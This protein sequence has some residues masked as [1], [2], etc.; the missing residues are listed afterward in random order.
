MLHPATQPT[1][2]LRL[3]IVEDEALVAME[4][5]MILADAG[6]RPV[7]IADD[8]ASARR[9]A[10]G[11][12]ADLALVDMQLAGGSSGLDV[13][14]VLADRGIPVLFVTGNCPDAAG[15]GLAIGCLHKPVSDGGLAIAVE[16]AARLI[17]G[18]PPRRLPGGMHLYEAARTPGG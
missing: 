18:Q 8:L 7:G 13:A 15:A 4:M 6:H 14:R 5:E 17:A 2:S 9:V 1:A 11:V 10:A 12:D 16:A 3:L